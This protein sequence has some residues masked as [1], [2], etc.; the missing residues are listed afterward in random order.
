MIFMDVFTVFFGIV[1]VVS[2]S[3]AIVWPTLRHGADLVT[4]RN[5]FLLGGIP[6][7]GF[8]SFS[9]VN[10]RFRLLE[11]ESGDYYRYFAATTLFFVTWFVVYHK[12]RW[13]SASGARCC[14][15][16]LR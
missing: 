7:V 6:F 5:A 4:V 12:V 16:G 8:A 3:W 10:G 15:V 13:P 2:L 9:H 11:Y 14:C 1:V